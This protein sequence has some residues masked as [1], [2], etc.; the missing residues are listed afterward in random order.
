MTKNEF[1]NLI[2]FCVLMENGEGIKDKAPDYI[3]EKFRRYVGNP[4]SAWM[5]G[6]DSNNRKKLLDY[7]LLWSK[8]LKFDEDRMATCMGC[9]RTLPNGLINALVTNEG[10]EDLCAICAL[11][12]RNE[13]LGAPK[14]APFTGSMAQSMFEKTVE[15]YKKTNQ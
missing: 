14:D 7:I 4:D 1:T 15:Y 5:Q 3:L 12:R 13:A 10:V 9:K 8:H 6:L 2:A 11:E